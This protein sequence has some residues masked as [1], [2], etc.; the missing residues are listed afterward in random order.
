MATTTAEAF[1]EARGLDGPLSVKLAYY[2][3][4]LRHL[5]PP[6]AASYDRLI[7]RLV[8]GEVGASAPPI[9]DKFPRFLLPSSDGHLVDSADLFARGPTIISFNRG[10]WCP[11]C[12]LEAAALVA[13]SEEIVALGGQIAVITPETAAQNKKFR[14]DAE[15]AFLFLCDIDNS[16]ALQL[17]LVMR[18]DDQLQSLL[19]ER[20]ID[21]AKFHGNDL[22]LLPLPATFVVDEQGVVRGRFVDPDFRKR[23]TI[24]GIRTVLAH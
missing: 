23:G 9:G 24:D 18:V 8:A 1:E 13:A 2:A 5:T 3:N 17:G 11:F 19:R 20:N 16:F 15:A 7:A 4:Q 22:W 14:A 10:H 21:L 12:R 6:I